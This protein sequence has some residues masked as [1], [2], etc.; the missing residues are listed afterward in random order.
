[1][2]HFK[3][4]R[5][6]VTWGGNDVAG[7]LNFSRDLNIDEIE[8]TDFD[9][10]SEREYDAG[11]RDTTVTL[12]LQMDP[13][14][15]DL[16]NAITDWETGVKKTLTIEPVSPQSGD[17]TISATAFA[18]SVGD[19]YEKGEMTVMDVDFRFDGSVTVSITA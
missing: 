15:T 5:Y 8:K 7:L 10:G 14:D 12:S 6:K 4:E 2:A 13:A 9:S 17:R 1:M 3:G 18:T 11:D 19:A 16:E